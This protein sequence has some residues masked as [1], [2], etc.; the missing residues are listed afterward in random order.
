MKTMKMGRYAIGATPRKRQRHVNEDD[1]HTTFVTDDDEESEPG[2]YS[3]EQEERPHKSVSSAKGRSSKPQT[4]EERDRNRDYW[5]SKGI[6]FGD[7]E[8]SD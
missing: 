7:I 5:L 6:G 3:S 2:E 4:P 1:Y 8:D